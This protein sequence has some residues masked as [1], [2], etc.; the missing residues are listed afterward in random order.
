MPLYEYK[1]NSCEKTFTVLSLN[2]EEEKEIKCPY[3]QSE[4][5]KKEISSFSSFGFGSC[6]ATSFG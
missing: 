1:C 3:C 4:D 2:T 5:V 6:S